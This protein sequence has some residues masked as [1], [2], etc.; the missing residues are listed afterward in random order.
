MAV[1]R[2]N[3]TRNSTANVCVVEP[4]PQEA[5]RIAGLLGSV[6]VTVRHYA[7]GRSLLADPTGGVLCIVSEMVLPDMT[8][9]ELISALRARGNR[10]PVILLAAESDVNSAVAGMRAGALDYIDK[11]QMER[12]LSAHLQQLILDDNL[13]CGPSEE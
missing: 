2:I 1:A 7:D 10:T 13:D 9:A 3:T 4:D 8:G 11:M 12:L 6:G 5:Q